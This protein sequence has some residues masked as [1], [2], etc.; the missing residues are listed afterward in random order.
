MCRL[1]APIDTFQNDEGPS[2]LWC[3]VD[4]HASVDER[5]TREMDGCRS[6]NQVLLGDVYIPKDGKCSMSWDRRVDVRQR[7]SFIAAHIRTD[8][9]L[10]FL[11]SFCRTFREESFVMKNE[12]ANDKKLVMIQQVPDCSWTLQ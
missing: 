12:R 6:I 9:Q 5:G 11:R 2:L 1:A 7:Y 3:V 8:R 4:D 10:P